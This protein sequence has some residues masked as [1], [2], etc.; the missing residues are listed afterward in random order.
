MNDILGDVLA[1][2]KVSTPDGNEVELHS[3]IDIKEVEFLSQLIKRYQISKTLEVG[4]AM[5]VSS[6]AICE[7]IAENSSDS[8]HII[9]DPFQSSDW[10]NIGIHQ[11]QRAGFVNY[12]LLE[13]PSEFALPRLVQ[14][15]CSIDLAF[16]DGW[17]TFDHTLIDF[18]YI[19]CMLKPGGIVI[20]DD[21][22]M[23]AVKRVMRMIHT[24]PA[25]QFIGNVPERMSGRGRA[26][27]HF[28]SFL[29]PI[30][31]TLGRQISGQIFDSS[32]VLSNERLGLISSVAAFQKISDDNRPWNWY[33]N[34]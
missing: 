4:C 18:F 22:G 20:V 14:Q 21:V 31:K 24:Y 15:Q 19:N 16:I 6:L 10:K 5:G 12:D 30:A 9:I 2:Q 13:E 7:A 11:L 1:R 28:K 25:Y 29:R 27:E 3:A 26:V 8:H 23:P 32:V 33:E 34:F 17:H